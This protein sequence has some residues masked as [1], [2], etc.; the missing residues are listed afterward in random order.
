MRPTFRRGGIVLI[1]AVMLASVAAP[2]QVM[3]A[4]RQAPA[5][6][7][8]DPAPPELPVQAPA[9]PAAEVD[10]AQIESRLRAIFAEVDGLAGVQ[11]EVNA[12][13]VRLTGNA[14][15]AELI[16][17]VDALATGMPGVVFVDNQVR[18]PE[19]V[20]ERIEPAIERLRGWWTGL[21]GLLPLLAIAIVI[22][23]A[24]WLLARQVRRW[25]RPF[26]WAIRNDL[27]REIV[28][29]SLSLTVIIIALLLALELLDATAL[30]G[31]VLGAAGI[32]GLTIGFAFRDIAENYLASLLLGARRPFSANDLVRIE[33]H[34]GKVRAAD[35]ARD[36]AG[37]TRR[38]SR[39]VA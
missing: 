1:A 32:V 31:A 22:L 26:A 17:R 27:I 24:G 7:G 25:S 10:D 9:P 23:V 36:H 37:H 5:E 29:Q 34:E 16:D 8:S 30:V 33:N 28:Q 14:P 6:P 4:G 11:V 21:V 2:L 39:A 19:A 12:G 3:A 15:S 13:V 18:Q 20:A 35:D 38:Q